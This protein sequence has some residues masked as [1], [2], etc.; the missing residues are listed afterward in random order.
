MVGL[1]WTPSEMVI[2]EREK[3]FDLLKESCFSVFKTTLLER[4]FCF[5]FIL[6]LID[7]LT[8]FPIQIKNTL[9]KKQIKK[10]KH[11][12]HALNF[13]YIFIYNYTSHLF[14]RIYI[15]LNLKI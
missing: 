5:V 3:D 12:S 13:V 7:Y 9:T 15:Y 1:G 4:V 6:Q 11:I 2:L 10:Q 14:K 8:F